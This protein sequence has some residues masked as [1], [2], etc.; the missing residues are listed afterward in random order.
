MN[1][2]QLF[3]ETVFA[4]WLC[5]VL[6][7]TNWCTIKVLTTLQEFSFQNTRNWQS[8]HFSHWFNVGKY[9]FHFGSS[10]AKKIPSHT[11]LM[12]KTP[13]TRKSSCVNARGHTARRVVSTPSVVLPGYPPPGGVPGGVP[14]PGYP[15][16]YPRGSGYPPRGEVPDPGTPP[17]GY[18]TRVPPPGGV[19]VPPWGGTWPGYPPGG[20]PRGG[21]R[22]RYPPRGGP[23][24]PPL[25]HG[26]LGNVAKHYGIWVPPPVDRQI[27]GW[28]DACQNITFPRTTYAGGKYASDFKLTG[29]WGQQLAN[30][31]PS[32]SWGYAR[33]S[34]K[35]A[36]NF[37]FPIIT[38]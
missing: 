34:S 15:R 3:R 17:G 33:I 36:S 24:T 28:T 16:G 35:Y 23:G 19:W 22:V 26:I 13:Q 5:G 25:P 4:W 32:K 12:C 7:F 27:D 38:H 10:Y 11:K 14:D 30:N 9:Q 18:L 37:I 1:Q 31:F 2:Q 8:W 21:T 6:V 20:V 29:C